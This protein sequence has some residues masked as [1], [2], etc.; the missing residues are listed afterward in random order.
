MIKHIIFDFDGTIVD[1]VDIKNQTFI[2]IASDFSGEKFMA[3]LLK[4]K[5]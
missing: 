2:E 1:S 5:S 3:D 4:K